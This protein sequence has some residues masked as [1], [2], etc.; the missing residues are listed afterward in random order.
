M[1]H[2]L[3]VTTGEMLMETMIAS[4]RMPVRLVAVGTP[5]EGR[6]HKVPPACVPR[7]QSGRRDLAA[8]VHGYLVT[9]H[10]E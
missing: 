3:L 10:P 2:R 4:P 7:G 9:V 6:G 5:L 8:A 1:S